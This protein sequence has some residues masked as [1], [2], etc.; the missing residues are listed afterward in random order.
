MA[1][2][3]GAGGV[4][5]AVRAGVRSIEHGIHLDEEAIEL[6]LAHETWLVPTLVAP[7]A[8]LEAAEAG[9]QLS[10]VVVDKAR[11]VAQ[12]HLVS[13]RA[14]VAAGVPVAMGTD[15]GVGP[16]GRN[17]EELPLLAE[18]GMTPEQVLASATSQAARLCGLQDRTGRLAPGLA[19]DV[20][21]VD[22]DAR[23]LAGL[24]ERIRQVWQDGRQVVAAG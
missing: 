4:K 22:G 20:V 11:E 16:H 21:V 18:C 7:R 9:A 19:G 24:R 12:V 5:N 13:V 15:S 3:Q 6:M 23:D 8:V 14:A 17:L 2:A 10:E 1:H